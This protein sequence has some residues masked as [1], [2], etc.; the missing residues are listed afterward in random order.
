MPYTVISLGGVTCGFAIIVGF[1]IHWWFR[2]GRSWLALVPFVFALLYGMLAALSAY[3]SVSALGVVT[4]LAIWAGNAAGF[5]GLVWGVG[6]ED[7]NVTRATPV[8]LES[9]GYV[10]LLLVTVAFV[11]LLLW[12]GKRVPRGK[13]LLGALS[14]ALLALSG[15]IAGIAAVPLGSATNAAGA[16]FTSYF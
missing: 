6:G 10:V 9:G 7:R 16:F 12:A 8:V 1:A 3:N 11:C 5:V 14:G 15:T 13:L 2:Q 4:W